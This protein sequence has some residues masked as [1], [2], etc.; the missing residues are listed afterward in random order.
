MKY[1]II[2]A[3]CFAVSMNVAIAQTKQF[4]YY[5]DENLQ[6][7]APRTASFKGIGEMIGDAMEFRL[8][9]LNGNKLVSI[10][11]YTDSSLKTGNGLFATFGINNKLKSQGSYVM[12]KKEGVWLEWDSTGL[13]TDSSIFVM[14]KP[15]LTIKKL[16]DDDEQLSNITTTDF[17]TNE[18]E[19]LEYDSGYIIHQTS[20]KGNKGILR[21]Y[22]KGVLSKT[23]TV[24]SRE[25]IEAEF[26]GGEQG[27]HRFI[28]EQVNKNIEA[29]TKAG[30]SGTCRV[31]FIVDKEGNVTD[32][33][34]ITLQGSRLAEIMVKI[35]K[36]SPKWKPASQYGR[37]VKAFREQPM[38]FTIQEN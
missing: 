30:Q 19:A 33:E 14:D 20:F 24:F 35:I 11:H 25:E 31:R 16:Y 28:I 36:K 22:N 37:F 27:W 9:A 34:A 12:G 5:F 29:L 38:S 18:L 8:Y 6:S 32:V 2:T 23:D 7:A 1:I 10:E 4:Q 26:P 3:I 13:L 17:K 21:S 15:I